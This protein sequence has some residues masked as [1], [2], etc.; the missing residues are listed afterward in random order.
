MI[1]KKEIEK[2]YD[3][4]DI[5]LK[6][7]ILKEDLANLLFEVYDL[8]RLSGRIAFGNANA[9]DLL[10]LKSSLKVLPEISSLLTQIKFYKNF[11]PLDDLY[12]LL[13][14]SIYENP[15]ISIKEGYL[16]KD[17]YNA[18]LD[19]LKSLRK[20]GKDFV[21]RFE[22]EEKERTGIKN[23]KVGYNRV[24]GYYIEVSKG[25]TNLV[26]E[27]YGYETLYL[28]ISTVDSDGQSK[29][30][31]LDKDFF[32]ENYGATPTVLLVKDNKIVDSHVGYSEYDDYA[33]FLE[34]NGFSKK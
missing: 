32:E 20:G 25:N 19:E 1:D 18:E 4:I 10:Q 23:L 34:K 16:I 3:T 28:D 26:K 2:R 9:K 17:G 22:E 29:I 13:E 6:E 31:D 24:F 7:F 14:K 33:K 5:L 12:E 21:A 11:Q 8:E 30:V 27:E 15:P